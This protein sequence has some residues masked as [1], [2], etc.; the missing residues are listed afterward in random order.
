MTN[1]L[2]EE[3]LN[4]SDYDIRKSK[5]GR[6]I[7]QK[8]AFDTVCFVADCVVDYLHNGGTQPFKSPEIWHSQYSIENVMKLFGKPNPTTKSTVDEYNKFF[9][10][11]LKMLAAAKVLNE[12]KKGIT[13]Q[14][15]VAN[16]DILEYIALRERN[17][18]DFICLYIEKT[19]KDSGLWD[20]FAS[21]FDE[22]NRDWYDK[23]KDDFTRFCKQYTPINT[24]VESGRIFNKVL[25]QLACKY[26]KKGTERG[27]ISKNIVTFDKIVYN[28]TNW[29]DDLTGKDKNVARGDYNG[30]KVVETPDYDYKVNRAMK[31]LRY[32]INT[33]FNGEPEFLDRFS[34]GQKASAIHHIFP[35]SEYP[36]IA[37]YLENLIALSSA[38]HM[39]EAHP[40][41]NTRAINKN[42]QYLLL[43]TKTDKIRKNILREDG[44]PLM[45]HFKDFMFVLDRGLSTEYFEGLPEGDYDAVIKGIEINYE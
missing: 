39:Q 31:N 35:K 20:S 24:T 9:R 26:R 32:F 18:F 33:Y 17:A 37:T 5:N 14:F 8:C 43:I 42:F 6:W 34:I 2:I 41:G 38:Q 15:S 12:E 4:Q 23:V 1:G 13:I 3:F 25:N 16:M 44:A 30:T 36:E 7:D 21:F 22:Q 28:K 40:N 10:Q 11:P 45:Y 27:H 19:L 29:Y